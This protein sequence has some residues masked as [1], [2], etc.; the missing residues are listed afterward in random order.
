MP[1]QNRALVAV[2]LMRQLPDYIPDTS[3]HYTVLRNR[4][5]QRL[6]RRIAEECIV[7]RVAFVRHTR[8]QCRIKCRQHAQRPRHCHC[9]DK[10]RGHRNGSHA[11]QGVIAKVT[12][13]APRGDRIA[14]RAFGY[15]NDVIPVRT[16]RRRHMHIGIVLD[17]QASISN[18]RFTHKIRFAG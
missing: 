13:S 17:V 15:G 18:R 3:A 5:V 4:H 6:V 11:E 16:K 1:S 14:C 9:P 7:R 10:S 8:Q 2:V 12:V